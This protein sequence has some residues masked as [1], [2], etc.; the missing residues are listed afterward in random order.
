MTGLIVL[1]IFVSIIFYVSTIVI[2]VCYQRTKARQRRTEKEIYQ[3]RI[4]SEVIL[5][6][7]I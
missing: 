4:G 6:G 2:I 5:Q 7:K 1:L 3:S